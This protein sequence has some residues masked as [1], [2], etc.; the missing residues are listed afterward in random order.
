MNILKKAK[1]AVKK[2][3]SPKGGS[4]KKKSSYNTGRSWGLDRLYASSEDYEKAYAPSRKKA[5]K[6][7]KKK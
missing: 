4:R 3:L 5:Y 6:T 7:R 1:S 2:A